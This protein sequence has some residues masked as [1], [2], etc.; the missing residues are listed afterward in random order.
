MSSSIKYVQK[1]AGKIVPTQE[2]DGGGVG[3]GLRE[4]NLILRDVLGMDLN[5]PQEPILNGEFK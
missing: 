5:T 4:D 1:M 2:L 3:E